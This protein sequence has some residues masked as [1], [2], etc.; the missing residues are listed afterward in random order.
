MKRA[1]KATSQV[2]T[3]L[4]RPGA[5]RS[6]PLSRRRKLVVE[7]LESRRVLTLPITQAFA[8]GDLLAYNG[9]T[10]DLVN[11]TTSFD[12]FIDFAGDVDSF[13]LAPQYSGS[14]TID[15]GDFGNA[16]DPEVAVY[17]AS[18][19]A[20]I[21]YNNDFAQFN[22]D[23][24]LVINLTGDVRYVVAV[25]DV[26]A[27]N[28]G[29][30]SIIVRAPFR[31]GSFL[32]TPDR[33]GDAMAEV[34]LD[35]PTDVDYYSITAPADANGGL[36]ITTAASTV[37][38]RL[39]LFDSAG[40]LLQGP[41]ISLGISSV[42]PNQ[43][44]RVAVYSDS[45]SSSGSLQ[46]NINFANAGAVVTNTLDAG[47]GSLRQ[48]IL[49]ANAHTNDFGIPDPIVFNIPGTGPFNI[50]L[51]SA[52]PDITDAVNLDGR[53]QPGTGATPTVAIDGTSL[54]GAV[55]GLVIK[56]SGSIVRMLN[57]HKFPAS[58]I[59]VQANRVEIV[60][61]TVGTDWAGVTALGNRGNGILIQGGSNNRLESNVVSA[62]GLSGIAIVGDTADVN[63]LLNNTVGARFGG[64]GGLG[65]TGN[66]ITVTDGDLNVL[67][68]NLISANKQSGVVLA[69]T[70]AA[71][72]LT[73]NK[74]GTTSTGNAAMPNLG[75][76][77]FI[78]SSR[79]TVGGNLP[80][81]RNVISGNAKSGITLSGVGASSNVI[82]GNFIGTNANGT[83]AVPNGSDGVRVINAA[84]NRIGSTTDAGAGNLISG[85][86]GSGV[87]ISAAGST[88]SLV[89]GNLIGTTANGLSALG[90]LGSG[91]LLSSG[92]TN[93]QIGGT[94]AISRNVIAGNGE[95]GITI[96]STASNNRVSLN[97]IGINTAGA[98]IGN[99]KSGILIQGPRNT[100]GG[101]SPTL[102]NII[103][104]NLH[105]VY[106]SGATATNNTIAFNTIGTDT[107][108]NTGRG[109]Q[110]TAGASTNT[111]GPKNTIRRN[112]TGVRVD[113]GSVANK[114]T[115][116]L[117]SENINLG[118][119]LLPTGGL[120][121]NDVGDADSGGNRLQNFPLINGSPLLVASNLEIS[122]VLSSSPAN[123]AYP[124]TIEF[125]VSDGAGEGARWLGSTLYTEANYAAGNKT[126]N[127]AGAGAGLTPGV[128]KIV[129]TAID[130]RGNTSEFS[131][132][133]V[134]SSGSGLLRSSAIQQNPDVLDVD[135]NGYLTQSDAVML[136]GYINSS[137]SLTQDQAN[138]GPLRYADVDADGQISLQDA[139]LVIRGIQLKAGN[140]P[141]V[142]ASNKLIGKDIW[143]ASLV[144]VLTQGLPAIG[145][146]L[147]K[148]TWLT[149]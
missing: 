103:A 22:D 138:L 36:T 6:R 9:P 24:R 73:A 106:L 120:T 23:A 39:A 74:I 107:A 77:V 99:A 127:F 132:Q 52:L 63:Q 125:F 98:P 78:Q 80:S 7:Q 46:L 60:E 101:A 49:D 30:V 35:V 44:Y 53:T 55:D 118:I 104:G 18:T 72:A 137:A 3:Q 75:D 20:R 47:P 143:D 13:F 134:L 32:L 40:T 119:D 27:L 149:R 115:Q 108:S 59:S 140:Q 92:A 48:A 81:L 5:L 129:G 144:E 62:N 71:N 61:N 141:A 34:T 90:N 31:T 89:L 116:N 84:R 95:S 87:S 93:I 79:N 83:V 91:V 41:F 4:F 97:R 113:D 12:A 19:G 94:H 28:V 50:L 109:I 100:I 114:I 123:A 11:D 105:G 135:G 45:F 136:V 124:L 2:G 33:F 131:A 69:G 111:I 96:S 147:S 133:R 117:I 126:V 110:I 130:L 37:S 43:E 70:A 56:A 10:T 8:E 65:N 102:A 88:G 85:N 76:G 142:E 16:V 66:G 29:N 42:V 51:A 15:V 86:R 17:N 146:A 128:T 21:A 38:Q 58:G 145:Q 54:T 122:F 67:T 139:L 25:A 57:I 64:G 68:G 1:S 121:A 148:I 14:Y 112:E 82:E 26:P